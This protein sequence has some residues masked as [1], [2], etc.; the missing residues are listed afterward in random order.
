MQVRRAFTLIELLV[1]IAILAVLAA[2]LFPV[3]SRARDRGHQ[4]QCL[5]NL[6]QLGNGIT[7]YQQDWDDRFPFAID[8]WDRHTQNI[9]RSWDNKIPN[10]SAAVAMLSDR[11]AADGS[12]FGGQIDRVLRPYTTSDAIWRC[13]GDTGAG[14]VG[15]ATST[16]FEDYK[17]DRIPVWRISRGDSEW[18]GTSYVYRT[19]L[20]LHMKP[21][22]RLRRPAEVNVMMDATFYWHSRLHRAPRE[23]SEDFHDRLQGSYNMLYADGH[24]KNVSYEEYRAAWNRAHYDDENRWVGTPFR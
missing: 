13:P 7:L 1:V 11:P 23:G 5:S 19:E 2:L 3:F 22:Q 15:A 8:F 16:S 9:W 24:V 6:R 17:M 4:V 14:G 21:V 20:G 18:G 12:P 10:A